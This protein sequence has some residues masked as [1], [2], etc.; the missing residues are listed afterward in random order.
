MLLRLHLVRSTHPSVLPLFLV[1]KA[2]GL[3]PTGHHSHQL[4]RQPN[5][6]PRTAMLAKTFLLS[7][8]QLL[9]LLSG[10]PSPHLLCVL[11]LPALQLSFTQKAPRLH[12]TDCHP[13]QSLHRSRLPPRATM[14]AKSFPLSNYQLLP[15]LSTG[16]IFHL[17]CIPHL[18]ALQLFLARM[19]P[20]LRHKDC[21][22]R[23]SLHWSS[24][25]PRATV[26][27]RAF[28]PSNYQLLSL[29]PTRPS[30]LQ[31]FLAQRAPRLNRT[32][33]HLRQPLD[34]PWFPQ[35]ITILVAI[36]LRL[37][38]M[39]LQSGMSRQLHRPP[40]ITRPSRVTTRSSA[41]T[42]N[43]MLHPHRH[44]NN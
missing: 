28:L 6:P 15:Q 41:N 17:L 1:P 4:L 34:W 39:F 21:Y 16:P 30:A 36:P 27:A 44:L 14:L 20:R 11:R 25:P 42:K 13:H 32:A 22:L 37:S 10:R 9:S 38:K 23:Q 5:S 35:R 18:P 26:L 29:L 33:C 8:Y 31:L 7:S 3:L 12:H 19:V 40:K 43:G 24:L 2:T